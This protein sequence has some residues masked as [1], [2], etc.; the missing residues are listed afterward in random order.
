MDTMI[1]Q[2]LVEEL[3]AFH[4]QYNEH[5]LR[6]GREADYTTGI[7]Q[8]IGFKEF[9]EYLILPEEEKTTSQGQKLLEKG[10]ELLKIATRKY[11]KYQN[12]WVRNR[13]LKRPGPLENIPAVYELDCTDVSR[14]SET[15]ATPAT[16]VLTALTQGE[17]PPIQPLLHEGV[18]GTVYEYKECNLCNMVFITEQ[19]WIAH[20]KSKKHKHMVARQKK[21]L[22]SVSKTID[23]YL[24]YQ[25]QQ[26][27]QQH[28][29]NQQQQQ[30]RKR[31][32]SPETD[33]VSC[34]RCVS[35]NL[36]S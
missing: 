3:T 10:I 12:K 19:E 5:R 8:S 29:H 25:Q 28:Q 4:T 2:G 23:T 6:E 32:H 24:Q 7:F 13:F 27:Q 30:D 15:V 35:E 34:A 14:W 1:E 21:G 31:Q 26:Q 36:N 11:A 18:K 9:H 16:R 33:S 22:T 20:T 17:D